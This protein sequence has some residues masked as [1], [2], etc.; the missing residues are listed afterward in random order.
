MV[1]EYLIQNIVSPKAEDLEAQNLS[2][3]MQAE[4]AKRRR[5][6]LFCLFLLAN[7]LIWNTA[8][9]IYTADKDKPIWQ[10]I[11]N[12]NLICKLWRHYP[13]VSKTPPNGMV[14][15]ILIN[16]ANPVALIN[17]K[18]VHEGDAL[19]GVKVIQI[20]PR[21]IQFEKNGQMWTQAVGEKPAS[22]WR[23][24][25]NLQQN[26]PNWQRLYDF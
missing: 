4:T 13:R 1:L 16:G 11:K 18:L 14:M 21:K 20:S 23:H 25:E 8:Y 22:V 9:G 15:G 3:Q 19:G 24:F 6:H 10:V 26:L 7:I 12:D 2:A 17:N 5:K